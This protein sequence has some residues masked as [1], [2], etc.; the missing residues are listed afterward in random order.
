MDG[1]AYHF[2]ATYL[3]LAQGFAYTISKFLRGYPRRSAPLLGLRH[4]F[5]L[6]SP[7]FPLF[8][9]YE[10]TIDNLSGIFV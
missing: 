7:A 2:P 5:P 9:F 3:E 6:G 10:T 4:Q 8:L 1:I